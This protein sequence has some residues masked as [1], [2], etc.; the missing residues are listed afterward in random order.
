MKFKNKKG[1]LIGFT[2]LLL[3][4]LVLFIFVLSPYL[5]VA[6]ELAILS[7]ATGVEAFFYSNLILLVVLFLIIAI[8]SVG[9]WA[10]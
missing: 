1:G 8:L 2:F 5:S 4:F 10:S 6:G 9:L 7:G 3:L